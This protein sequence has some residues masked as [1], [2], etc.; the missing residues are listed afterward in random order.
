MLSR[1]AVGEAV[2][3]NLPVSDGLHGCTPMDFQT[4][5]DYYPFPDAAYPPTVTGSNLGQ[6]LQSQSTRHEQHRSAGYHPQ[7]DLT[8]QMRNVYDE[9]GN[10]GPDYG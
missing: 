6:S 7:F 9:W 3:P 5:L 2:Q 4:E 8:L 1:L 10:T